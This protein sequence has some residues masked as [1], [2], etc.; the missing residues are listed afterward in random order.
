MII[1]W[2]G[3]LQ[4]RWKYTNGLPH[5]LCSNDGLQIF[6]HFI[7]WKLIVK[8]SNL[9][10]LQFSLITRTWIIITNTRFDQS[11]QPSS[12]SLPMLSPKIILPMVL[13]DV[14]LCEDKHLSIF[15]ISVR[16]YQLTGSGHSRKVVNNAFNPCSQGLIDFCFLTESCQVM[17][18][19]T[20]NKV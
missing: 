12:I 8:I 11:F 19:Y 3:S 16:C 1:L 9:L 6:H 4:L 15:Q 7:P 14:L 5:L 17:Q 20:I 18:V 13:I 10:T 2:F